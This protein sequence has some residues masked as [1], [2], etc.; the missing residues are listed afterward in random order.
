MGEIFGIS[1]SPEK[2]ILDYPKV[3]FHP[4]KENAVVAW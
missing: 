2:R 1:W 4:L 3:L